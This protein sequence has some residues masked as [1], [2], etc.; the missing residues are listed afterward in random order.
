MIRTAILSMRDDLYGDYHEPRSALSFDWGDWLT[1]HNIQ[2]I[3]IPNGSNP[4]AI[5]LDSINPMVLILTGGNDT[6][7]FPNE[8]GGSVSERRDST[9]DGLI[10]W[11]LDSETPILGVCRGMH[12]LNLF[13]GGTVQPCPG[14]TAADHVATTHNVTLHGSFVDWAEAPAL[15]VNSFHNQCILNDDLADELCLGA[16]S[17][18]GVVEALY[19]PDHPIIAI[20]W[21]PERDQGQSALCA[22]LLALLDQ[23]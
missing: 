19:H 5:L 18:D 17:Q 3:A 14:D 16:R 11:A 22:K 6:V 13:F 4:S 15:R 20:Q 1:T 12:K 9:E 21:H 23:R 10:H 8:V 2:P 7:A